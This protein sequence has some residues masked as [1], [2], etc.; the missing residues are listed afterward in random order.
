MTT[1][2]LVPSGQKYYYWA[3]LL[4]RLVIGYGFIVHGWAKFHNGPAGFEKLLIQI[5]A[6]LP[7]LTAWVVPS[8][9][10]LGG[11]MIFIGAFVRFVSVPLIGVMLVAIITVH[12]KY[13][14]S[15]IKTIGLTPDGPIF[16]PPG[17]EVALLYIA[18]LISLILGGAGAVSVDLLIR[19][20]TGSAANN[21]RAHRTEEKGNTV[22]SQQEPE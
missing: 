6:P 16:G 15:S 3:P 4:I 11:F 9:E 7:G 21:D 1:Q 19:S 12:W 22:R 8:I 13:G 17:Y 14:F 18:G 10:V 5:G 20:F 2:T